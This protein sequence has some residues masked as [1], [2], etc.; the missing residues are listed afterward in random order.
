M[1]TSKFIIP[2]ITNMQIFRIF[3]SQSKRLPAQQQACPPLT[4]DS[5]LFNWSQFHWFPSIKLQRICMVMFRWYVHTTHVI[6]GSPF[7]FS[8]LY[9]SENL[10]PTFLTLK[11][12]PHLKRCCSVQ[13][14]VHFLVYEMMYTVQS[15]ERLTIYNLKSFYWATQSWIR[16]EVRDEEMLKLKTFHLL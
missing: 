15:M 7:L 14:T 11:K 2:I 4:K 12:K 9:I 1:S 10:I 5:R 16:N 8:L 6:Q 3:P 13:Y